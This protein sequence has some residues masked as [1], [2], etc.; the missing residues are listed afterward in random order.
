MID[1][2]DIWPFVRENAEVP[3]AMSTAYLEDALKLE[4]EYRSANEDYDED[5][6]IEWVLEK[7]MAKYDI[8]EEQSAMAAALIDEVQRCLE[9]YMLEEND[10][11]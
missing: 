10:G 8:D 4:L 9:A 11:V 2:H 3:K 1:F 6:A 7:L 5:D